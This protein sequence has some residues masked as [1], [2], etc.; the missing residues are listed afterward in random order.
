[1]E[2]P[3]IGDEMRHYKE[4]FGDNGVTFSI[5]NAGKKS[6]TA[7]LKK[8]EDFNRVKNLIKDS[9]IV[10]EQFRPGVM[11]KLGLGYDALSKE[12]PGLIYCSITGFGQIGAKA[13]HAAHD[14]NYIAD[15]GMLSLGEQPAGKA[16]IP[17]LLAADIAGGTYPA[18]MNILLALLHRQLSGRGAYIDISMTDFLFPLMFWGLGLGWGSGK[19]PV[20]GKNLLTG[21]SPRYQIY[22]TSDERLLAVAALEDR[23]W[24]EF[25]DV[26][27]FEPDPEQERQNPHG[28]IEAISGIISMRCA[29]EWR[30]S[31]AG[32]DACAFIANTLEEAFADG[33]YNSRSIFSGK[34]RTE[35][36]TSVN[37]L[38]LPLVSDLKF[39]PETVLK[40]PNL[41]EHN[42]EY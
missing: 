12:T 42:Q 41:G 30:Q 29:N 10:V 9:D 18:V 7:D 20:A 35:N 17:P 25:C 27:S 3:G 37:A 11:D 4:A 5:L 6:I 19:W 36:G 22:Q 8:T 34:I 21:G 13:M 32:R 1:M 28:M 2:R 39:K 26:I 31:F 23:F 15:S 24:N 16:T 14:L 33:H 38:P 40:A